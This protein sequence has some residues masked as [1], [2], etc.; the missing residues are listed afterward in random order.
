MLMQTTV[1]N[2][3]YRP[4]DIILS[5][6]PPVLSDGT[7]SSSTAAQSYPIY[8]GMNLV[9]SCNKASPTTS[10]ATLNI[11]KSF[12]NVAVPQYL[13]DITRTV[14]IPS[15]TSDM[16]SLQ[17]TFVIGN[18]GSQN[19][20]YIEQVVASS[21]TEVSNQ[22]TLKIVFLQPEQIQRSTN[23]ASF[24]P[25]IPVDMFYPIYLFS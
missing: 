2:K 15:S 1:F 5:I 13:N 23:S 12:L 7:C 18:Y 8:F 14:L 16:T 10:S 4:L 3:G 22:M 6:I 11:F 24:F 17:L 21:N 25:Q 9:I 20:K 19:I